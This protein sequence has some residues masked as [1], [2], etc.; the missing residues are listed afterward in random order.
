MKNKIKSNRGLQ[1][2]FLVTKNGKI[3][4]F[5][6]NRRHGLSNKSRKHNRLLKRSKYLSSSSK[7]I[8]KRLIFC[9]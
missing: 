3:K 9:L 1:K 4:F 6:S 5:S 8:I 7:K 2:R